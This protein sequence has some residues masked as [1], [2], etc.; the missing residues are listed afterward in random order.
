MKACTISVPNL[1]WRH[2]RAM[3][4]FSVFH[5]TMV[6]IAAA[7]VFKSHTI[8]GVNFPVALPGN[9]TLIV[10]KGSTLQ[11]WKGLVPILHLNR[12]LPISGLQLLSSNLLQMPHSWITLSTSLLCP[13]QYV[14]NPPLTSFALVVLARLWMTPGPLCLLS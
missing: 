10:P 2:C 12:L 8:N 5:P 6:S 14:A 3:K 1:N 11:C 13:F 9:T 7:P 4:T